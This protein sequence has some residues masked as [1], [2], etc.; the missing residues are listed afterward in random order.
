[1]QVFPSIVLRP[2]IRHYLFLESKGSS[3]KLLRLFSDGNTGLVFNS[4]N[5]SMTNNTDGL[6]PAK[7]PS[8]FVYGQITCYKDLYLTDEASMVIVVFQ[9]GGINQLLGIPAVQLRDH[10][11]TTRDLFGA[12]SLKLEEALSRQ[13]PVTAK[14]DLL[15][16]F[17]IEWLADKNV[18]KQVITASS[19]E[20][21]VAN[22]GNVSV[23]HLVK[24]VGYTER[25]VERSFNE[26][27]GIS[28]RK[29]CNIV[30]LHF[31]LKLLN[32]KD[33]QQSLTS[34]AYEAGYADQSHLVKE[35][36]KY[37]GLV[38]TDYLRKT[39]KLAVNFMQLADMPMSGLYNS[40]IPS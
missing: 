1:M 39:Q 20:F 29:F 11:V 17:F 26:C 14:I 19:V 34:I 30:K 40:V 13:T 36:R 8:S 2:F 24:H 23:G 35:F 32:D 5:G 22:R 37:T 18:V 21:I 31:F 7:L 9:P 28:P 4:G 25:H 33:S 12:P 16:T 3:G 38:P 27:I 10:V 6:L 15:N